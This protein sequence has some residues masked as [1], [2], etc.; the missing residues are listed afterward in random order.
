VIC[1]GFS[2]DCLETL[3]EIA[4]QNRETFLKAGGVEYD[5]IPCLNDDELHVNMLSGLVERHCQGWAEASPD[6]S[7]VTVST[8]LRARHERALAMGAKR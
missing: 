8:Q 2:A 1:P 7:D 4:M 3:E 5:Y 6:Y